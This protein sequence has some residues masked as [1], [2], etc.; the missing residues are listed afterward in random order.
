MKP[1]IEARKIPTHIVKTEKAAVVKITLAPSIAS[2][3]R[4]IENIDSPIKIMNTTA[5]SIPVPIDRSI[6]YSYLDKI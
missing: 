3:Q 4:M 1:K 2:F 5:A 6:I